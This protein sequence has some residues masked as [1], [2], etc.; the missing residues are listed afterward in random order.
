[1]QVKLGA[2]MSIRKLVAWDIKFHGPRF[3]MLEFG[4]G[5]PAMIIFG[6]WL[7]TIDFSFAVG[8]YLIL[9]GVNYATLL[10][11]AI[12]IVKNNSIQRDIGDELLNQKQYVRKYGSQQFFI[13]IPLAILIISVAQEV[14]H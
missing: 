12:S 5:A 6:Y 7:T 4:L 1:M 9:V 8:I 14:H 10:F 3:I 2:L 13:L 11:Y